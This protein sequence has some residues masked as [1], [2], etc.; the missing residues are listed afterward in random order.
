MINLNKKIFLYIILIFGIILLFGGLFFDTIRGKPT[1]LGW[2]QIGIIFTGAILVLLPILEIKFTL[3]EI[4]QR[5]IQWLKSGSQPSPEK[6]N[7]Y[8]FLWI[9]PVIVIIALFVWPAP[10]KHDPPDTAYYLSLAKNL[11]FGNGYVNPDLS[12]AIYRGPIFPIFLTIAY[13]LLGYSTLSAIIL[14]RFFW[15]STILIIY[16][17]GSELYN[18]RTGMF[19][20]VL[21]AS[22]F[23]ISN[24]YEYILTDSLLICFTLLTL[25]F[26]WK[27]FNGNGSVFPFIISGAMLGIAY[28]TKQSALFL[29]PIPMLIWL[30]FKQYRNKKTAI[31]V[32]LFYL[33]FLLFISGW[34]LYVYNSG[35]STGQIF[36]DFYQ[37]V[38]FLS[39]I[40][41]ALLNG[42]GGDST[43]KSVDRSTSIIGIINRLWN[44]DIAGYISYAFLFIPAI[45]VFIYR[46]IKNKKLSEFL[47][48]S[49]LILFCTMLPNSIIVN[50]GSRQYMF[51]Y[52]TLI[53]ILASVIGQ[54]TLTRNT[55]IDHTIQSSIVLLLI[56]DSINDEFHSHLPVFQKINHYQRYIKITRRWQNG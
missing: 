6:L 35:G 46:L 23:E 20:A 48:L 24:I 28:L 15:A 31:R 13:N 7:P 53:M 56:D 4:Y 1:T 21:I 50:Y 40:P 37:I 43:P 44:H 2:F 33:I 52:I 47:I 30:F 34:M 18:R 17:W 27:A 32:G 22:L 14:V 12:P 41:N 38:K 29:G 36:G 25:W 19:A 51:L 49:S 26:I 42:L 9:V 10:Q 16:F 3:P 8:S 39:D 11:Y 55:I 45:L 5:F 54:I